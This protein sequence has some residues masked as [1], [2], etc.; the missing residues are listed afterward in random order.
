MARVVVPFSP[1]PT[2]VRADTGWIGS[3]VLAPH[4]QQ[5]NNTS[6]SAQ[7]TASV[8]EMLKLLQLLANT[9]RSVYDLEAVNSEHNLS[10]GRDHVT[11]PRATLAVDVSTENTN[12]TRFTE[13]GSSVIRLMAQTKLS[14]RAHMLVM[15]DKRPKH[16]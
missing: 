10:I 13:A 12:D 3:I 16:R 15:I 5:T 9:L 1:R 2:C 6:E 14:S 7:P 8:G 11:M 4:Q